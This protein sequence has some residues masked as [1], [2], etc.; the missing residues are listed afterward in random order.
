MTTNEAM[1]YIEWVLTENLKFVRTLTSD[2]AAVDYCQKVD[3]AL[4]IIKADLAGGHKHYKE[5]R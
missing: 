3:L 4:E 5:M 2:E 1:D